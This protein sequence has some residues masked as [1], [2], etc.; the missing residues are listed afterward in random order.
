MRLLL[1]KSTA[2]QRMQELL[3]NQ[4]AMQA[5]IAKLREVRGGGITAGGAWLWTLRL[6]GW[7]QMPAAVQSYWIQYQHVST[8]ILWQTSTRMPPPPGGKQWHLGISERVLDSHVSM[9]AACVGQA[10]APYRPTVTGPAWHRG[11]QDGLLMLH[12]VPALD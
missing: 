8:T 2:H 7:K 10:V 4:D 9:D 11:V 1:D 12:L 6:A 5:E 3:R